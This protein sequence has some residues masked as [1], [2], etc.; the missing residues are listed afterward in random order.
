MSK[1]HC[2]GQPSDYLDEEGQLLMFPSIFKRLRSEVS[3]HVGDTSREEV[4]VILVKANC[5]SL[6]CF[7]ACQCH[8]AG[9]G[10]SDYSAIFHGRAESNS[11]ISVSSPTEIKSDN[12]N[13]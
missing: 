9:R 3:Q 4:F 12:V 7:L 8:F 13:F 1:T 5:T 11:F 6:G 2:G 10:P